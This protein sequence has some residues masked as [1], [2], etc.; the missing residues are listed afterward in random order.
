MGNLGDLLGQTMLGVI[1]C[2]FAYLC[3]QKQ[4][5]A[6]IVATIYGVFFLIVTPLYTISILL[7]NN[8][9]IIDHAENIIY[10]IILVIVVIFSYKSL[11]ELKANEKR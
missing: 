7:P 10:T 4:R 2:L 6:F 1:I 9:G 11:Q 3:W 8:P 5:W